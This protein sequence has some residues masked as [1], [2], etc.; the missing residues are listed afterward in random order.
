MSDL[1]RINK[2]HSFDLG[3][4]AVSRSSFSFSEAGTKYLIHMK[5][6]HIS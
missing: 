1:C 5:N 3:S 6:N 2:E 4:F